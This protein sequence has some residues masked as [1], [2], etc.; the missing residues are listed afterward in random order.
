VEE[1]DLNFIRFCF[2]AT[3]VNPGGRPNKTEQV[4]EIEALQA[5]GAP[6]QSILLFADKKSPTRPLLDASA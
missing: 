1:L 2:R 3:S 6:I 5:V 4:I